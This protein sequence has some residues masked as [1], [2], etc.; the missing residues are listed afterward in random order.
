M[1]FMARS[2]RETEAK[3]SLQRH[4]QKKHFIAWRHTLDQRGPGVHRCLREGGPCDFHANP[5]EPV[6]SSQ[7]KQGSILTLMFA[8]KGRAALNGK[9]KMDPSFRWDDE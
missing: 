1:L 3:K 8:G 2:V 7:R 9:I 4:I 6:T 5:A